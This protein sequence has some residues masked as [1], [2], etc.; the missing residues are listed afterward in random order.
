MVRD[1]IRGPKRR[2]WNSFVPC[3][4]LS[5]PWMLSAMLVLQKNSVSQILA[6]FMENDSFMQYGLLSPN[7]MVDARMI[8][9]RE[10]L[11]RRID[12][13]FQLGWRQ[14]VTPNGVVLPASR[15]I[16]C[17]RVWK[18]GNP[19][20]RPCLRCSGWFCKTCHLESCHKCCV[21]L[22]YDP[23]ISLLH[24]LANSKVSLAMLVAEDDRGAADDKVAEGDRVA[25]D[26]KG[27]EG[28]TV[29]CR[30]QRSGTRISQKERRLHQKAN[31][32]KSLHRS[33]LLE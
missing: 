3:L 7:F 4:I 29:K 8:R 31:R 17:G 23:C 1:L 10:Q 12:R 15:C 30:R 32:Q 22:E 9:A 19:F 11:G 14:A 20:M 28:T 24:R 27:N 13:L 6:E 16:N 18:T 5:S 25:A 21:V 26:D 2:I 33:V